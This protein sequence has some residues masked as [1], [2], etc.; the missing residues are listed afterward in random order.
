MMIRL[1]GCFETLFSS[2]VTRSAVPLCRLSRPASSHW[3]VLGRRWVLWQ[4]AKASSAA[5][6]DRD[7][8]YSSRR[9]RGSARKQR[10]TQVLHWEVGSSL[11]STQVHFPHSLLCTTNWNLGF[12]ARKFCQPHNPVLGCLQIRVLCVHLYSSNDSHEW[13]I[14]N[15]DK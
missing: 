11:Q 4:H 1:C 8:K 13:N 9:L 3:V 5:V 7:I 15:N 2:V 10:T 6:C 14:T 12:P